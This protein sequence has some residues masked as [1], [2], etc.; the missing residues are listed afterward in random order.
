MPEKGEFHLIAL[1]TSGK[2]A[3]DERVEAAPDV[4]FPARHGREVGLHEG[5][6]VGLRDLGIAACE[7]RR[8]RARAFGFGRGR[9]PLTSKASTCQTC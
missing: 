4:A 8:L 3:H 6:A 7:E 2:R 9:L 5:V 1:G